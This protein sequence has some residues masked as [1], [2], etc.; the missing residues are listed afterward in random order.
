[1]WGV[2]W[3]AVK[4]GLTDMPPLLFA[5][6]RTLIGG[7]ALILVAARNVRALRWRSSWRIY[8]I[9]CLLN[10][11][12]FFGLQTVGLYFLPSGLLSVLVYFEPILVGLLASW[13]LGERL[14]TLKLIGLFIGFLGIAAVSLHSI[15]GHTAPAGIFIGLAAAVS[16]AVGTVYLKRVQGQSDILWTVAIQFTI[17]G[18]ILLLCGS[19][20][21]PW[22]TIHITSTL[23]WSMAYAALIG[24]SLSWV[25]WLRL[26]QNGAVS[27][28][29]AYVF[30]VPLL[31]VAIG[32]VWLHEAISLGLIVGLLLVVV[33][34]YVVNR[35][36]TQTT[37]IPLQAKS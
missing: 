3:S 27:T 17:G 9:S 7:L 25:V 16:W 29:S 11:V 1:M 15:T 36:A 35:D 32:T 14:T 19:V 33:S 30:F 34:I 4:V 8:M 6:F 22:H 12:L 23:V 21:E 37:Q 24:V 18:V 2:T 20:A 5:G 31:S 28:I 10:V 26:V 13:W